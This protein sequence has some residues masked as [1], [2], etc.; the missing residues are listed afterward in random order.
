MFLSKFVQQIFLSVAFSNVLSVLLIEIGKLLKAIQSFHVDS[1]AS[2]RV[3]GDVSE[4]FPVNV[5]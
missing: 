5:E 2:V 4:W 1:R 3:G